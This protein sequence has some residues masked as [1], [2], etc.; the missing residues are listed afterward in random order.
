MSLRRLLS[1]IRKEFIHIRRDKPSLILA[2]M[3]PIIFIL[4]FGYAVR[5]EVEDVQLVVLD[6]DHTPESRTLVQK[7]TATRFFL[8]SGYRDSVSQVEN[9]ILSGE[10]DA[11]LLIP[12][13]FGKDM[14]QGD[15]PAAQLII[16]GV[17][18]TVASQSLATSQ[19]I[20]QSYT[21]KTL[22]EAG[23]AVPSVLEVRTQVRYNPQMDSSMFTIPGLI[24]LVMQ[25]ITVML[26][27]FSLV[28]EK[29]VGTMELLIVTPIHSLELVLGKMIPY[30]F[31]GTFDY[32]L[33]LFFGTWWFEVPIV[34]NIVLL[35]GLGL[36][37]VFCSLAIGMLISTIAQ[38]QAQALQLTMLFLLPSVILSGFI[39]PRASMPAAVQL[40][41]TI[42][43]LTYF[44]EVL[45]GIILKGSELQHL[46]S[47]V[48]AMTAF[49]LVLMV[50]AS[51]RFH[52]KLD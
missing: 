20:A 24:G 41:G 35:I 40:I 10:F 7:F 8:L 27:S 34:G 50:M 16:D 1:V 15:S 4:M 29:E 25:N 5:T 33:A 31:L 19:L 12:S 42:I 44:L 21:L 36:I 2:L 46:T 48:A 47:Q 52:K 6:M 14:D 37:F 3:L 43:P 23:A 39:F 11:A 18:P 49:S 26:T 17:D 45:R 13:G 22:Q 51:K 30:V 32:L 9:G 38:N 28:R